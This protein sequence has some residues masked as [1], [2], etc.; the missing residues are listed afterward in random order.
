[1]L[2]QFFK[3]ETPSYSQIGREEHVLLILRTSARDTPATSDID[4]TYRAGNDSTIYMKS[5]ISLK[6]LI[7]HPTPT[8]F[9]FIN[10]VVVLEVYPRRYKR[11]IH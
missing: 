1:M 9:E 6:F 4:L 7:Y 8:P 2:A 11:R 3:R 10:A 5:K